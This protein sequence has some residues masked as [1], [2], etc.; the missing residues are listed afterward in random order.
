[1]TDFIRLFL[2]ILRIL[3]EEEE[4]QIAGF[5]FIFDC[6][7]TS[8]KHFM[9]PLEALAV[10]DFG[11]R[12]SE[13]RTKTFYLKNLSP[14]GKIS[15]D[16]VASFLSEKLRKRFCVVKD[17][18]ELHQHID[19]SLLP[20]EHGGVLPE[21]EMMRTFEKLWIERKEKLE[22]FHDFEIDWGKVPNDKF[23]SKKQSE[24]IDSFRKLEID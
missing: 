18:Y 5:D 19:P 22:E 11:K 13:V 9:N 15:L 2:S 24:N 17:I 10:V 3:L 14:F 20:K 7:G 6:S 1:M 16:T 21:A 8:M 23:Q 12:C 4:S